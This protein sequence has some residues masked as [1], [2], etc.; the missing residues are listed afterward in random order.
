MRIPSLASAGE[1]GGVLPDL[2]MQGAGVRDE[3]GE[4]YVL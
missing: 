2:L 3:E 4:V 1:A